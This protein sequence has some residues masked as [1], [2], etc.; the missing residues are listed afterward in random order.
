MRVFYLSLKLAIYDFYN[1]LVRPKEYLLLY[2]N[3]LELILD[4]ESLSNEQ[5]LEKI[6][7][8]RTIGFKRTNFK[9]EKWYLQK[10]FW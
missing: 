4:F 5:R 3:Y 8:I 1:A 7:N 2:G 6:K 10:N 9:E